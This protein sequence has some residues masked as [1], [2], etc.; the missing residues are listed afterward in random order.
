[1]TDAVTLQAQL[2]AANQRIADLESHDTIPSPAHFSDMTDRDM[3]EELLERMRAADVAYRRIDRELHQTRLLALETSRALADVPKAAA[4]AVAEAVVSVV[5]RVE[6][7]EDFRRRHDYHCD[8]VPGS[9]RAA[10]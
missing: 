5:T 9:E 2:D 7:L 6:V 1:M 4:G 10:K 3:L 8:V